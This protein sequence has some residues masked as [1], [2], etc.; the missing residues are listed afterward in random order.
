MV[1]VICV[2]ELCKT[3]VLVMTLRFFTC[4]NCPASV[5]FVQYK[6]HGSTS[7][8]AFD[9]R[10]LIYFRIGLKCATSTHTYIFAMHVITTVTSKVSIQNQKGIKD[11]LAPIEVSPNS[12]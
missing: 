8:Y 10:L 1:Y 2:T 9:K 3:L 7:M 6:V 11:S 12:V 4:I 5:S